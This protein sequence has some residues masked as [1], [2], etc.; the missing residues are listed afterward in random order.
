MCALSGRDAADSLTAF[1]SSTQWM[2]THR[3]VQTVQIG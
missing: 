2:I 3:I 1:S